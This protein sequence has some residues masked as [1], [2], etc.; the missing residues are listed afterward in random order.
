MTDSIEPPVPRSLRIPTW[1]VIC[2]GLLF[3]LSLIRVVYPAYRQRQIIAGLKL[4]GYWVRTVPV[5][6]NC[7]PTWVTD[8][9]EQVLIKGV[10]VNSLKQQCGDAELALICELF[11]LTYSGVD[12]P[13]EVGLDLE[14][15]SITDQGMCS[16]Q[17]VT[18]LVSLQIESDSV[19][20][21]GLKHLKRLVG[22]RYLRLQ[23]HQITNQ[24][25]EH[26]QNLRQLRS[27]SLSNTKVTQAGIKRLSPLSELRTLDLSG[28][29]FTDSDVA[30]LSCF[31]HLNS[32][33]LRH[34]HLQGMGFSALTGLKGKRLIVDLSHSPVNDLGLEQI[35]RLSALQWLDLSHTRVS[36]EGLKHLRK[37]PGLYGLRLNHT[38]V[39][40]AAISD[41]KY[42]PS[43]E[44]LEASDTQLTSAGIRSLRQFRPKL[45]TGPP[46]GR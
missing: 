8:I 38:Q 5:F 25:L 35:A 22:L 37:L 16:L 6:E 30:C 32:L 1:L 36:D 3:V 23:C 7:S 4:K 39:S 21:A 2:V 13:G 17:T 18:K 41:L 10:A 45:R 24:G 26:L 14:S 33:V 46:T 31:P 44:R 12:S 15:S 43:L 28:T 27:L 11:S 42:F 19:S 29:P 20:D 34:T 9:L 40:D